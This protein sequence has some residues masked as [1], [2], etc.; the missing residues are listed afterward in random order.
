MKNNINPTMN[1]NRI[2]T[3]PSSSVSVAET[4]TSKIPSPTGAVLSAETSELLGLF[5]QFRALHNRAVAIYN[6]KMDVTPTEKER[7]AEVLCEYEGFWLDKIEEL[8]R[9]NIINSNYSQL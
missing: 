4:Q 3:M 9:N 2:V 7:Q 6:R 1:N 5:A 8:M